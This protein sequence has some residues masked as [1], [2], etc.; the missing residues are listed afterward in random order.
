MEQAAR[1]RAPSLAQGRLCIVLAALLWSTSGA[2]TKILTKPTFLGADQPPIQELE[3]HGKGYYVQI[4]AYR[5][6]FA[7]LVLA[8]TV[9]RGHITF[10]PLMAVMAV[11]FAV[12]NIT[13]VSAQAQ[14]PAANAIFLQ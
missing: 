6:L 11:S 5:A 1:I 2:F 8:L 9:R 4:A 12:M 10:R 3:I 14:G 13:F 7:G